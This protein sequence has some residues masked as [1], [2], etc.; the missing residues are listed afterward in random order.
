MDASQFS[1]GL[2]RKVG[3]SIIGLIAGDVAMLLLFA[4]TMQ[5]WKPGNAPLLATFPFYVTCSL[6]GWIAVG[7]P[8]V[9][10]TNTEF[11][12]RL[13][14]WWMLTLGAFLGSGGLWI[15]FLI[16]GRKHLPL[17]QT[18][19]IGYIWTLAVIVAEVAFA[20]YCVLVRQAVQRQKESNKPTDPI[21]IF[22]SD[23]SGDR[24]KPDAP[25]DIFKSDP[26]ADSSKSEPVLDIYN[27]EWINTLEPS[28][29]RRSTRK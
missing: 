19:D 24:V 25:L 14:W 15:V 12:V 5:T 8:A 23:A 9:L 27:S 17:G 3:Y 10:F 18:F 26:S 20:V 21:D 29:P 11:I 28:D 4:L 1:L 2:E 13:R 6:F 16:V 7:L 22:K